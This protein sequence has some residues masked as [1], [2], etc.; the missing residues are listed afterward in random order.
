MVRISTSASSCTPPIPPVPIK[1]RTRNVVIFL[2]KSYYIRSSSV[3]SL[4]FFRAHR[5]S[6]A[7][8]IIWESSH[9]LLTPG[10][11]LFSACQG[12]EAGR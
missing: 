5:P 3:F 1:L 4:H 7:S 9:S 11:H 8:R 12:E 10:W 2:R 6:R